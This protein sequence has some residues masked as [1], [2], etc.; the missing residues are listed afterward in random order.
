MSKGL[1]PR[2]TGS[3]IAVAVAVKV[4]RGFYQLQGKIIFSEAS[5]ILSTGRGGLPNSVY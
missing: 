4:I 5:V 3:G 1:Q 2:S